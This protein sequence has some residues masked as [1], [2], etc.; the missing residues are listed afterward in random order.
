MFRKATLQDLGF[1]AWY[2]PL[3]LLCSLMAIRKW[4]NFSFRNFPV[5][6]Q[7]SGS[8]LEWTSWDLQK[9]ECGIMG[10]VLQLMGQQFP[11]NPGIEY[12]LQWSWL[13]FEIVLEQWIAESLLLQNLQDRYQRGALKIP[14]SQN[15]FSTKSSRSFKTVLGSPVPDVSKPF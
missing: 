11:R 10:K 2:I 7:S 8:V 6:Y 4:V 9:K 3:Y 14:N 1:L 12:L 5:Q 13:E 15:Q